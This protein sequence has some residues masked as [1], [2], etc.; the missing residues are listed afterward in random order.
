MSHIQP[1]AS[2]RNT[3]VWPIGPLG[4]TPNPRDLRRVHIELAFIACLAE[5]VGVGLDRALLEFLRGHQ[6]RLF[7]LHAHGTG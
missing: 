4:D 3:P 6:H 5:L 7:A 1:G 2:A